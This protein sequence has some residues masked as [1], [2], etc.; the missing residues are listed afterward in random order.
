LFDSPD[1]DKES[2]MSQ[3]PAGGFDFSK[4]SRGEQIVAIA[5][6]VY[7]IWAFMPTWYSCCTVTI[8]GAGSQDVAGGG[9]NGFRGFM[10]LAWIL[11]VVA[12]AEIVM[13]AFGNMNMNLP[14]ARGQ[15]HLI[16]AGIAVVCTLLGIIVKPSQG[17]FG[18]SATAN[19]SWG[20]FVGVIIAL[21]WAYG[22]YMMYS[23]PETATAAPPVMPGDAGGGFTS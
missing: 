1:L 15:L 23:S 21:V 19:L 17:A 11:A 9:V 7:I 4:L 22:A 2:R 3:R 16:I 5:S 20:I 13:R 6:L 14:I 10:I 12:L 8:S 18:A